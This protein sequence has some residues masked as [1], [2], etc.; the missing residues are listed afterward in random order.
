M[1]PTR[2]RGALA[3][4]L[5]VLPLS[6]SALIIAPPPSTTGGPAPPDCSQATPSMTVIW[7]PDHTMVPVQV[8][9]ITD[10]NSLPVLV[11][12]TSIMQDESVDALGSGNTWVDGNG[13]GSPTAFVRAER[14]GTGTGR[15][16]FISYTATNTSNLSCSGTVETWVPHDMGQGYDPVDT[17]LRFDS[18]I[19]VP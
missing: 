5:L 9:G 12:V 13:V 10:P 3:G 8:D 19:P 7:P 1:S 15:L 16:Y 2:Y 4:A 17:G 14:S 11:T 6:A 18:T